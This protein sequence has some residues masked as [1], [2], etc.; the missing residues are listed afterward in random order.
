MKKLLLAAVAAMGLTAAP[1]MAAE[2]GLV[3]G[4]GGSQSSSS[5]AAAS[6]GSSASAIAGVTFQVSGARANSNGSAEQVIQGNDSGAQSTHT[7][8]TT[9]GGTTFSFG[10]AGS[11]NS[12]VAVANGSSAAGNRLVGVWLFGNN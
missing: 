7:S 5:A 2:L 9:Q 1:A 6:Q 11:Q 8:T 3:I 4:A 12:N 10:L